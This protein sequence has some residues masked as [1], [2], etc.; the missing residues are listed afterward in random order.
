MKIVVHQS[1]CG[2]VNKAWGLIKTTMQD[3][4]LAKNIAFR[5]D[6]QDQTGGINWLPAIRGFCEGDYFL[7]MKT[8]EDTSSDVRRGRKFS[9]V[10]I[11]QKKEI[12]DLNDIEQIINLLPAKIEKDIPLEPIH[13]EYLSKTKPNILSV[14]VQGRFNKLINGYLNLKNYKNTLIWIGQENFSLAV[15]E[16]WKCLTQQERQSFQFGI[17]FNND[18]KGIDGISLITVPESVQ[19]K[20]L[21]SDF[22]IIG[23]NDNHKPSELIEQLLIGDHAVKERIN[24]FEKSI[25][26]KPL[27]RENINSLAK[28]IDTFEHLNDATDIK[29]LN[30]LSHII[31]QFAPTTNQGNVYKQQLLEKIIQLIET[32]K[33]SEIVVLR[34]FKI[35]SYKNSQKSLS[36][37]LINWM[38]QNIFLINKNLFDFK[39]FFDNLKDN[40]LNWWDEVVKNEIKI[41]LETIDPFKASIVYVWLIESPSILSKINPFID[42]SKESETSFVEKFPK[43]I[44]DKL[45]QELKEFSITNNWLRL[46][47]KILNFQFKLEKALTELFQVDKDENYF[48]AIDIIIDGKNEIS[49]IQY[50]IQTDNIRMIK[51]AGQICHNSPKNLA[52]IDVL[53]LN[54][55]KIW[56]EAIVLGNEI[57]TGLKEP[58]KEIFKLFDGLI[59]EIKFIEDLIY[60]I[61]LSEYSNLLL[62]PNMTKLWERLPANAKNNFL[63]NTSSAL[64][65]QLS[66]NSSI[67][68]P[69]DEKLINH[70]GQ[71]GISEF[72]Y[73]NRNNIK[74]VIPIFDKFI[75]LHDNNLRDYLN[76]YSGQINAIEATQLGRLISSRRFSNSAYIIYD[77][78]SKYNNWRFA[79][80]E[81]YHLLDLITRGLLA[82]S[83][84]LST[85]VKIPTDEWW[86]GA[87][88]LIIELYPNSTSLTTIWKK[89][90]GKESDLLMNVSAANAWSDALYKLKKT[91]LKDLTMNDLLKEIKKQYSDNPKFKIIYSL[92]KNYIK[93]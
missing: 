88:E 62:Y 28:G 61:S 29:K 27:S 45:V 42:K 63:T 44:S 47:S 73:Y 64:L 19:S 4:Y 58:E 54:W 7:I 56:L 86:Q 90:G 31:A 8:F 74:S 17:S 1:I 69:N 84:I 81:C 41:Y 11:I 52:K 14:T 87:E 70:I 49:I 38:T 40:N 91:H 15:I 32:A 79:L 18:D 67:V 9:H 89:S 82:V 50:A 77:K 10:L 46:F 78:S 22:F 3:N 13:L 72:L 37:T 23:K 25:D 85:T 2:E 34:N 68:I 12:V 65:K 83:G 26:S 92:R 36:E 35:E 93:T 53:N 39:L 59:S 16:F 60:Q 71:I 30:T 66:E 43:N 80:E 75:Q 21:K 51:K 55:Q 76:N 33:F 5:T 57:K 48:E 24:N 6:L 20:F